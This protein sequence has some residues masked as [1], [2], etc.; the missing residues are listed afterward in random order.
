MRE[1]CRDS[2]SRFLSRLH[3]FKIFD[4]P[5]INPDYIPLVD[6]EGYIYGC[7]GLELCRFRPP[8]SGIPFNAGDS[9]SDLQVDNDWQI[10]GNRFSSVKED[11]DDLSL[12]KEFSAFPDNVTFERYLFVRLPIHKDKCLPLSV[13]VL[14]LSSVNAHDINS[15][16]RAEAVLDHF[17]G[18]QALELRPNESPPIARVDMLELDD[19]IEGSVELDRHSRPKV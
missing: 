14:V 4:R 17:P 19:R 5:R 3:S 16:S 9:F 18:F 10:Y 6:E 12:L 15:F 8:S 13:D 2:P 1:N 7:P 11:F